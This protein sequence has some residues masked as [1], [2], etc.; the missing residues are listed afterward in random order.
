[1]E[2]QKK[3]KKN[4]AQKKKKKKTRA[5]GT[6]DSL[7]RPETK[8]QF[9][10]IVTKEHG[11]DFKTGIQANKREQKSQKEIYPP[12]TNASQQRHQKSMSEAQQSFNK[13]CQEIGPLHLILY[14]NQHK[15]GSKT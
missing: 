12:K 11:R 14:K 5:K 6:A 10:I 7:I 1:M 2:M 15:M 3:K 8:T 13:C 4:S 9:G